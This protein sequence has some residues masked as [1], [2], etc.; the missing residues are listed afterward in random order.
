MTAFC[1]LQGFT[2]AGSYEEVETGRGADA[3]EL[4]PQ[5]RAA[6]EHAKRLGCPILV[7]KLDR[8]SRDVAFISGLM[9]RKTPVIVAELGEDIDPFLLHIYAAFAEKERA[10]ISERTRAA[11]Q[12]KKAMGIKLGNLDSLKTAQANGCAAQAAIADRFALN[13]TPIIKDIRAAGVQSLAAIADALNR[14]GIAT[15]RGGQWH[16]ATVRKVLARIAA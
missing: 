16:A 13:V 14:R 15:A 6:L 4:R 11:L 12:A 8:L 10:Q 7:A 1:E 3:L 5:L 2:I 9:A